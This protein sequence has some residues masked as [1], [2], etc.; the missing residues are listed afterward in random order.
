MT[1]HSGQQWIESGM[2]AECGRHCELAG[3]HCEL[4][5]QSMPARQPASGEGACGRAAART[6]ET[7]G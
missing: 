1:K 3:R 4:D 2:T 5:P 6:N 7:Q